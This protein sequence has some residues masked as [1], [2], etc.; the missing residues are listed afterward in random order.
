[1]EAFSQALAYCE[2]DGDEWQSENDSGMETDISQ[3][4]D[5]SRCEQ[6]KEERIDQRGMVLSLEWNWC[7]EIARRR[8]ESVGLPSEWYTESCPAIHWDSKSQRDLRLTRSTTFPLIS[9]DSLTWKHSYNRWNFVSIT[10]TGW[11]MYTSCLEV[12]ILDFQLPVSSY[13]I[14]VDL[15]G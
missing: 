5:R 6:T 3:R 7:E 1:M 9:L 14:P 11:D 12:A 10:S 13:N 4:T 15:V 8:I 2:R